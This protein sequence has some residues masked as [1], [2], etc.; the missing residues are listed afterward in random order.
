MVRQQN[1]LS[2]A[3]LIELAKEPLKPTSVAN[4]TKLENPY[5]GRLDVSLVNLRARLPLQRVLC[6]DQTTNRNR[7]RQISQT[8]TREQ[9]HREENGS[10]RIEP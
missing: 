6:S 4:G 2:T 10:D 3:E 5:L 8:H 1:V 9:K 7:F